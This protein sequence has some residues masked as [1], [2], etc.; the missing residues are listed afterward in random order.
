[1]KVLVTGGAGFIGSNIV[2]ELIDGGFD[3]VVVDNLSTGFKEFINSKAKFYK[4]DITDAKR[5]R[6]IF[7]KEK[8]D[9]V[10]HLAAQMDVRVSTKK[11]IFDATSNIIGSLNVIINSIRNNT[12][13]IIYANT[14]GAL[15]G[16]IRA[17]D[18]PIKESHLI[19]PISEYGVSKHT[20][21]HYLFLYN[22]NYGLDY[23]SLRYPNVYGSR[24]NPNGE[25]GVI[26]I[27]IGKMLANQ[28]PIIFGDGTQTRDYVYVK[29]VVNANIAAQESSKNGCYNIGTGKETSILEIFDML[30]K[31]LNFK[32]D[33]IYSKKRIGE[34]QRIC[35]DASK[36][37]KELGWRPKYSLKEGIKRTSDYYRE[38]KNV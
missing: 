11:P 29:D 8:P 7:Q 6:D 12:K 27:F 38:L 23:V 17:E 25:A 24:Q 30:K 22:Y 34:I 19:N 18:L 5:I 13:K 36:I 32:Q 1:M 33:P 26:A 16:E 3:V 37:K 31:E 9:Y 35:L 20:V 2:D 14:G 28:R 4:A 21:E 10:H 15:Y